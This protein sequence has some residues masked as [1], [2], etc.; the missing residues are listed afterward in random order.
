[1][2]CVLQYKIFIL[3]CEAMYSSYKDIVC[4]NVKSRPIIPYSLVPEKT[5]R[6]NE[7][8]GILNCTFV[9]YGDS[10]LYRYPSF[11]EYFFLVII[12]YLVFSN[13]P[14]L[15]GKNI[16]NQCWGFISWNIC[17]LMIYM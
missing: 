16:C 17:F 13:T 6:I 10:S 3:P 2:Y 1:M 12:N 11:I 8:F 7:T 4:V 5:V 9:I 14:M 15:V